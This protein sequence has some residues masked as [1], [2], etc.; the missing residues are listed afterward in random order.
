[1]STENDTEARHAEPVDVGRSRRA[2]RVALALL[3]GGL[4]LALVMAALL[5]VGNHR[6]NQQ[7]DSQAQQIQTNATTLGQLGAVVSQQN[8]LFRQVCEVAGG[9]VDK[10]PAAQQVCQ[11]VQR[12]EPAVPAPAAAPKDGVGIDYTRQLD[13]CYIEVGLTNH[14]VNKFGPFCGSDGAPGP[15]GQTGPTG[16]SGA[17][18][19]NGQDGAT[20]A[21]GPAGAQGQAGVGIASVATSANRCYVDVTLTDS[22]V[23]TI[24]PFCGPPVGEYTMTL[25]DGTQ[26]HCVR[27]GGPDTAPNY[28][29]TLVAP[30]TT[31]SAS[32]LTPARRGT[33]THR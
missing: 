5:V 12:G 22:S 21:P 4:A 8:D 19:A 28:T 14:Q 32:G 3:T 10:N 24:G 16:P 7:I 15:T 25:A 1:M 31:T 2:T 6:Q 23:H 13:R 27:D 20:G 9:Q 11:R 29:C 33:T 17:P 18:G 30:T 26:Q